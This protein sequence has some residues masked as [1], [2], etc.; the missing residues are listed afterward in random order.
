[1][2]KLQ[3]ILSL[4]D[5]LGGFPKQDIEERLNFYSEMIEDHMEEGLAEEAAVAAV[6]SVEEI[7]TQIIQELEPIKK[8]EKRRLK[9][10]E[11]L[12]II[13]GAPVWLSLAISAF[14][15]I[16][17]IYL[18]LWALVIS[19]WATFAAFIAGGFSGIL[20][21]SFYFIS[22]NRSAGLFM[23]S[24]GMVSLGLSIFFYFGCLGA[25]KGMLA[26]TKKC[27]QIFKK[28]GRL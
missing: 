20:M 25:T 19:I 17:A 9:G 27:M 3:F 28:E 15:V 13:L 23:L 2:T 12:V 11:L 5:Q 6:G 1:M 7:A 8:K 26:L 24:A 10:W 22:G 4:R 21:G 18:S 16:L 14:S